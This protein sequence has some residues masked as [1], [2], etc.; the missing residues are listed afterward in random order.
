MIW[1]YLTSLASADSVICADDCDRAIYLLQKTI[2]AIPETDFDNDEK[3]KI[4]NYCLEGIEICKN[5]KKIFL[6]NI[7]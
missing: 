7:N 2:E 3:E 6:K 4:K 1:F 5:D